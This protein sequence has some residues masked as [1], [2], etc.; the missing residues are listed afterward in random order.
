MSWIWILVAGIIILGLIVGVILYIIYRNRKMEPVRVQRPTANGRDIPARP[1]SPPEPV[2]EISSTEEEPEITPVERD[3]R[4]YRVI[5]ARDG[6][7]FQ[8]LDRQGDVVA[9]LSD[10]DT[11]ED[12][13]TFEAECPQGQVELIGIRSTPEGE[14]LGPIG[15]A[16]D[17]NGVPQIQYIGQNEN[18]ERMYSLG[19]VLSPTEDDTSGCPSGFQRLMETDGITGVG[20]G[21]SMP[22]LS[23]GVR[24]ICIPDN[25][26]KFHKD[27]PDGQICSGGQCI[28]VEQVSDF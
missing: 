19:R 8:V 20:N 25:Q 12:A 13:P 17:A 21:I 15:C 10:P 23:R 22:R 28:P 5:G 6:S 18:V 11:G 27:C 1:V 2:E 3:Y 14:R 26:C 7:W 9:S 16:S 24:Y 4:P